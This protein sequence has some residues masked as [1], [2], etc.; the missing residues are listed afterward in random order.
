[1]LGLSAWVPFVK[2]SSGETFEGVIRDGITE[3]VGLRYDATASG[4]THAQVL[5]QAAAKMQQYGTH[6]DAF[7]L[8]GQDFALLCRDSDAVK[9]MEMEVGERNIG[10]KGVNVLGGPKGVVPVLPD[11]TIEQGNFYG[12]PWNS[13]E[14]APR[15]KHDM[16]LVNTDNFD[17]LE[18]MRNKDDTGYEQRLF[19]RGAIIVPAPGKFLA[20]TGLPTS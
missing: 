12:G 16:E 19:S 14:N 8:S 4:L 3:L 10:F 1:M 5:I 7:Y 2:P 11:Y 9:I 17:G 15:L 13:K 20:G 6:A 18:F